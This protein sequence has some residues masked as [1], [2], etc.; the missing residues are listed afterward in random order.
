MIFVTGEKV[1]KANVERYMRAQWLELK[2]VRIMVHKEG[3]FMAQMKSASDCKRILGGG[4][5]WW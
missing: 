4:R 5:Q 1:L 2:P 3:Y